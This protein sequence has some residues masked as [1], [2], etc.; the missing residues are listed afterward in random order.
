MPLLCLL[1]HNTSL[2][3]DE[4]LIL[5]QI[6]LV[7]HIYTSLDSRKFQK[8]VPLLVYEYTSILYSWMDRAMPCIIVNCMPLSHP[9]V[10]LS[11]PHFFES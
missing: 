2:S 9:E 4:V 7:C 6:L 3:I 11:S 1:E 10:I 5:C 8:N